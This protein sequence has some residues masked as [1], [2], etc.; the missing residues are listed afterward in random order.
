MFLGV[1]TDLFKR[2]FMEKEEEEAWAKYKLIIIDA[3][4]DTATNELSEALKKPGVC[5][6]VFQETD[7]GDSLISTLK[8]YYN[9]GGV[10]VFFG[11]YGVYTDPSTLSTQFHLAEPWSFSGYTKHQYDLTS[12]ALDYYDYHVKD[13]QYTKSNLIK[14]PIQDRW[15]VPKAES[16]HVYMEERAGC[17]GGEPPDEEWKRDAERAKA[18]YVEHCE[19]LYQYCPLAVHVNENGGKLAYLGFVNGDGNIPFIVRCLVTERPRTYY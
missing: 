4:L 7:I 8:D 12:T 15:M 3:E 9:S 11:I 10:V 1:D 16:L 19:G 6:V 2:C 13:Q 14:V 17:L 5:S 18:D